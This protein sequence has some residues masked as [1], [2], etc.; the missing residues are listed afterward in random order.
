MKFAGRELSPRLTNVPKAHGGI[1][2]LSGYRL[3]DQTAFV[4]IAERWPGGARVGNGAKSGS[5]ARVLRST[6]FALAASELP[7]TSWHPQ[8]EGF[9]TIQTVRGGI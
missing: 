6:D 4:L 5:A 7:Y 3:A 8:F 1:H 2:R 9:E